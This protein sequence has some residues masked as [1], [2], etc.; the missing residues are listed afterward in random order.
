MSTTSIAITG[1]RAAQAIISQSSN[2]IANSETPGFKSGFMDLSNIAGDNGVSMLEGNSID[3]KGS[4]NYTGMTTD[5]AVSNNRSFFI[6]KNKI[7]DDVVNVVTGSF[8][9]NKD[10][11]LE[12][13]GKYLLMGA[14]YGDD[15]SLPPIGVDTLQPI[16]I[17]TNM[18]SQAVAT[19]KVMES[20]NLNSGLLAKGQASFIMTPN[21]ENT[22]PG[23]K[24]DTPLK[25][26]DAL[27][28]GSGFL[29]QIKS[30]NNGEI[31]TENTKCIFTAAIASNSYVDSGT[32]LA[33]GDATD[34]I[35][36]VYN[37][38][39]AVSIS[40]RDVK[41]A[42][43]SAI[44]QN[45]ADRINSII[46]SNQAYVVTSSGSSQLVIKPPINGADSLFISGTL[47]TSLNITSQILPSQRGSVRFTSMLDLKNAL[48][49]LFSE[50][51]SSGSSQSLLF[52][53]RPNTNVSFANLNDKNDVLG[54]LGM[55]EG[56]VLGQGYDPYNSNG[57]MAS[58]A[59]R[60]DIAEAVS[61][62]DSKGGQHIANVALKKVEDGWIQEVYMSNPGQIYG[63]RDDGLVQVT[64]FTFDSKG[65]L[66]TIGP[67]VPNAITSS[68]SDPYS[69]I[70][71]PG[72]AVGQFS[73]GGVTFELG[74]DFNNMADLVNKINNDATLSPNF[75][76]TIVKD[77][78]GGYSIAVIAKGSIQPV[79]ETNL[80]NVTNESPLPDGSQNLK[81]VF[82]PV[83]NLEPLNISFDYTN[84]MESVHKEMF[85]TLTSN[86]MGPSTLASISI[87]NTGDIIGTFANG[88]SKKLYK[89]PLA[90]YANV[91]GLDVIGDNALR[92]SA[93]SGKM[94]V[95]T[96]GDTSVGEVLSG[97]IET[98]NVEQAEELTSLIT[99][100]QF[101]N[102]NT[103]S[104]QTGNAILDYLL[105]A[106]N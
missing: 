83:E 61:F 67:V 28:S 60:P 47:A 75:Q 51:S 69:P 50:V 17:N 66:T 23:A 96:A 105:N 27:E 59:V 68:M 103:K 90:T 45:I 10:G 34:D 4:L 5:L 92:A 3:A 78:S 58:G 89:I 95:S 29:M 49:G 16:V 102:M 36:I 46:G 6:V 81:I 11:Q 93:T 32:D 100:K 70:P 31:K 37:G 33:S 99:N 85:G 74:K 54:A 94:Q 62:Y 77:A 14:Q 1:M 104:W 22:T 15:D 7:N 73:L 53:A 43:D 63:V 80:F 19:T 88:A 91:N 44:L 40:R 35:S 13:L 48:T 52:T 82:N 71:A 86:G 57:N 84:M 30:E 8:K 101:Y 25:T 64:K 12:Y 24:L 97:N 42:T 41:G 55:Y 9:P 21:E 26:S 38:S 56:P 39:T 79:I 72:G 98:S 18:M 2:N 20:F 87:D 65:K 76:A 106:T